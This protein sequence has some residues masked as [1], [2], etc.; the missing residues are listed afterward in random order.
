MFYKSELD[1]R[2]CRVPGCDH[3]CDETV[4]LR[5]VC[6]PHVP[7]R[8]SKTGCTIKSQCPRCEKHAVAF[9]FKDE[10]MTNARWKN[11]LF[12]CQR[13]HPDRGI[14]LAYKAGSG[15]VK[16]V[17]SCCNKK[18]AEFTVP[19]QVTERVEVCIGL[20][21]AGNDTTEL[22]WA[23]RVSPT[24]VRIK[25][26]P[27]H[28]ED[29]ASGDLVEINQDS[30]VTRVL[31]RCGRTRLARYTYE[32]DMN[33]VDQAL[34]LRIGDYLFGNDLIIELV[35]HKPGLIALHVPTAITDLRLSEICAGSP[36]PLTLLAATDVSAT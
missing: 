27:F 19:D 32:A 13:C 26:V 9:L 11:N 25:S 34:C 35:S 1:K 5:S 29:C 24:T 23:V 33:S 10:K 15:V 12:L 4:Q 7:H 14:W 21:G 16:A 18:V 30:Q 22:L 31:E 6:H 3:S 20:K 28:T 36:V 8:L 17:C 2:T